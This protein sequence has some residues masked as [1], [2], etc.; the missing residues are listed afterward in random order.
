MRI[1]TAKDMIQSRTMLNSQNVA[2]IDGADDGV[3]DDH[4]MHGPNP[5]HALGLAAQHRLPPSE[6]GPRP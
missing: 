2:I 1:A 4:A 5:G 3:D 6:L